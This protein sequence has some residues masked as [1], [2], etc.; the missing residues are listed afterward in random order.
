M[1]RAGRRPRIAFFGY[2]DVFEDFYPHYGVTQQAFATSWAGSGNHAFV[3]VLQREVGDVVWYESSLEPKVETGCHA[4][5][6]QVNI[7]RSAWIH[8]RLWRA[9][10]LSRQATRWRG[11]YPL[12]ALLASYLA[13]LSL[14]LVLRL[15]RDR[16]D[17]L[18]VQEYSSGRYDVL[19]LMARM[20]GVPLVAYH[21]GGRQAR[22]IGKTAKRWTIPRANAL[23]VSSRDEADMLSARYG[24][25]RERMRLVLTPIDTQAFHPMDRVEACR[26]SGLDPSRRWLLFVGRLDDQVKRIGAL[27]EAFG[28]V[29]SSHPNT[30]LAIVGDGPDRGR[31]ESRADE[32]GA[33][34]IR[35]LGW[36]RGAEGLAPL[37][38]A[39]ECLVLPSWR[40]G[41]PTVV[42][43]AMACGTPV[44]ASRVGGV[45]ELVRE[46]ETGWMI[47]PGDDS[48]LVRA[49]TRVL[50]DPV[51]V[52]SMRPAARQAAVGSVS[53]A[54][55]AAAL[56]ECF[57]FAGVR[58]VA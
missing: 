14:P 56:R 10:H 23:V 6:C 28:A 50:N 49:L 37:Y 36:R 55:V 30:G 15:L 27:I 57:A 3:S 22:Y 24:V 40:E 2:H 54:V 39:A 26:L 35:F 11:I 1:V 5:G 12:Y 9:F 51:R 20:V 13:P 52:R 19:L 34:R 58:H 48:A 7:V 17:I 47:P 46:N 42:G 45:P 38:S 25:A 44:L 18:F 4:I 8:R 29:E 31:L 21:A 32:V 53:E 16:P 43:E 33:G 41:F